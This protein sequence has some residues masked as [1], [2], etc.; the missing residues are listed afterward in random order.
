MKV[1]NQEGFPCYAHAC[2]AI[3]GARAMLEAFGM[4]HHAP[5]DVRGVGRIMLQKSMKDQNLEVANNYGSEENCWEQGMCGWC[6]R[7]S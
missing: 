4:W 6:P 2:D 5:T 3:D 1:P 7:G